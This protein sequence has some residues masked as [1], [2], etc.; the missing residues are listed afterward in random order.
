M[1]GSRGHFGR[2][3]RLQE[4]NYVICEASRGP[5]PPL[6]EFPLL[7]GIIATG[8]MW[9]FVAMTLDLAKMRGPTTPW[10]RKSLDL[11]E[12]PTGHFTLAAAIR[13]L[14]GWGEGDSWPWFVRAVVG[15]DLKTGDGKV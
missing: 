3:R 7:P 6:S 15:T 9:E 11:P 1:D 2:R 14:T 13:Y 8:H 12:T 10:G 4:P 5:C